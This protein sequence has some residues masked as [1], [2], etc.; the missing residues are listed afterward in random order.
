VAVPGGDEWLGDLVANPAA[1]A[2][3]GERR[4]GHDGSLAGDERH[5]AF[6]KQL[7]L[8]KLVGQGPD[9]Y[10]PCACICV[11]AYSLGAL[12]GRPDRKGELAEADLFLRLAQRGPGGFR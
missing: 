2:T 4:A 5:D 3:P 8:A 1:E 11:G 7:E 9:E 12:L 6:P 10:A